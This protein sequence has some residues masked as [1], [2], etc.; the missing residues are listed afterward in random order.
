M[1]MGPA[2]TQSLLGP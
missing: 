2:C 1:S